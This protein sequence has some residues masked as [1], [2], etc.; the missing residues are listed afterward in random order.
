M[1]R[2]IQ[3]VLALHIVLYSFI[4]TRR[5]SKTRVKGPLGNNSG[6]KVGKEAGKAQKRFGNDVG[7]QRSTCDKGIELGFGCQRD[8]Q[9]ALFGGFQCGVVVVVGCSGKIA[10]STIKQRLG[11]N[12]NNQSFVANHPCYCRHC[13]RP[14]APCYRRHCKGSVAPRERSDVSV[15]VCYV[16]TKSSKIPQNKKAT[17]FFVLE[18]VEMDLFRPVCLSVYC[19]SRVVC[20]CRPYISLTRGN[21]TRFLQKNKSSR[22]D[23]LGALALYVAKLLVLCVCLLLAVSTEWLTT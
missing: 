5:G 16:A 10:F 9:D 18:A 11:L 21:R 22:R 12:R 8:I 19:C 2:N 20:V 15:A 4:L 17:C 14:C 6:S 7:T 13:D 1:I 3:L 23:I